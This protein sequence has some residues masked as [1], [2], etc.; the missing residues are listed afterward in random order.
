MHKLM[1]VTGAGGFIG[2]AVTSAFKEKGHEVRA[3]TRARTDEIDNVIAVG[4]IG[5]NTNWSE[6][7]RG[8][9][10]V[11]HCAGRAHIFNE[12]ISD[13]LS[14]FRRVNRDGTLH[15][16]EQAAAAGVRRLVFLSSVGVMGQGT[17]GRL[18]FSEID[19][20]KPTM[21][22]A[23]SKLEA[24]QGLKEIAAQT[25]LE[26][27]SLRPPLV[28]GPAAPGN[29]DRLIRLLIKGWP[30]PLGGVN[31]NLRS[32]IGIQN[33]VDLIVTCADHPAAASQTFLASDGEDVS[34]AE[35]LHR[36]GDALGKPSRLLPF[37]V[38]SLKWGARILGKENIFQSLCGSLQV[39]NEKA[40][41]LLGWQPKLSLNEGLRKAVGGYF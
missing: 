41:R 1:A 16:A 4:E 26:V 13:S 29:F 40:K 17:D 37:P 11:I 25:S 9:D 33:L 32:Y 15:M 18:P 8:V 39:D 19:P 27:V 36:M 14:E 7:F 34:T 38:W 21:A 28:Y 24:E 10:C 2:G 23:V 35:L 22:Y 20:P 12:S 30:L 5:P 3:L 31:G 6:A